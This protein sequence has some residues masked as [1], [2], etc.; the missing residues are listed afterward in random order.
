MGRKSSLQ[1]QNEMSGASLRRPDV[2]RYHE[3]LAFLK[4]WI[5]FKKESTPGF[6]LR[7]LAKEA[8]FSIGYLPM[9]LSQHRVL[10]HKAMLK[11]IPKMELNAQEKKYFQALVLL[12]TSDS[13]VSRLDAL[14]QMKKF[15]SYQNE[16]PLET[17]VHEYLIHWYYVAIREMAALGD[18]A[19]DPKWLQ[20]RLKVKVSLDEIKQAFHFLTDKKYIVIGEDGKYLFQEKNLDCVGGVYRVALTQYHQEMLALAAKSITNTPS[21]EREILSH[22]FALKDQDLAEARTILQEAIQKISRL[23]SQH[24]SSSEIYHAEFALFPL[25][26]RSKK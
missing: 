8:E 5:E 26:K 16:N 4:D 14:S 9:V 22:T 19:P 21:A 1:K 11:L 25:T 7:A 24:A 15:Q 6:S 2:F 23:G 17:E 12:S 20:S 10:S 3:H 13:Q 18:F